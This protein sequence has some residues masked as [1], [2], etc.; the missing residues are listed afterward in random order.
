MLHRLQQANFH[1]SKLHAATP[2]IISGR[3]GDL[4]PSDGGGDSRGGRGFGRSGGGGDTSGG[5]SCGGIIGGGWRGGKPGM[6]DGSSGG[7]DGLFS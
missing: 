3:A 5:G 1:K 6:G 4:S 7:G 2:E